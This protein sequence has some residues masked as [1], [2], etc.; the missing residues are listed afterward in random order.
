MFISL[1]GY[2]EHGAA[3]VKV[4]TRYIFRLCSCKTIVP[5]TIY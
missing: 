5:Q 4:S 3:N 2:V 1:L